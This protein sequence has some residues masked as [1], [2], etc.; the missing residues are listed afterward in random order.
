M[1][2]RLLFLVVALSISSGG[3]LNSDKTS[4]SSVVQRPPTSQPTEVAP[5]K[6]DDAKR[7]TRMV[8]AMAAY[9]EAEAKKLDG[10]PEQQFKLRDQAR[11]LFQ[12]A[13]KT[14]PNSIDAH[15]GL[16]RIYVDLGDFKLAQE[17]LAKAQTKFPKESIFWYEQGQLHN[18]RHE[19]PEAIKCLQKAMDMEPENR[20]YM[21]TCGLTL[22][23]TGQ[24]DEAVALLARSMGAAS[25]HYNVARM[26]VHLERKEQ[27]V[28]HLRLALKANGSLDGARTLL[29][30]LE[31]GTTPNL[32]IDLEARN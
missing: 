17:T 20:T 9:K 27:A 4:V 13:A 28:Q 32:T 22:A 21:T 25:A 19:F 6:K 12:E 8:I 29:A 2:G 18:R 11:Q 16:I 30:Q 5:P 15:R 7:A 1:N 23:R 26:L 24:I 10:Q 3:C 31:R 14:D